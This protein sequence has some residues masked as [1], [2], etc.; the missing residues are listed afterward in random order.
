MAQEE[1]VDSW[2]CGEGAAMLVD[3]AM[4]NFLGTWPQPGFAALPLQ[5]M[6]LLGTSMLDSLQQIH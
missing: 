3:P 2:R 1:R 6:G 5:G 4:S